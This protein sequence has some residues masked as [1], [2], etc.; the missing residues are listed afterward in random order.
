MPAWAPRIASS[1]T[2][3][4]VKTVIGAIEQRGS[5][6]MANR[7]AA[8]VGAMFG[9]WIK[10]G[11][12]AINPATKLDRTPET[13]PKRIL[14]DPEIRELWLA[15]N[16]QPGQVAAYFRICLL[17]GQ[18]RSEVAGMVWSEVDMEEAQ[19]RLPAARTKA[20]RGHAVPLV[21]EAWAIV[22]ALRN[23]AVPGRVFTDLGSLSGVIKR[24]QAAGVNPR[25]HDLRRTA[26]SLMARA[27]VTEFDIGCVLNHAKPGMASKHYIK[28]DY[29]NEKARALRRLD[30]AVKAI[31]EGRDHRGDKVVALHAS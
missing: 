1:L 18:R 5:T 23:T 14:S 9:W 7:T 25:P 11:L 30:G 24:L 26:S 8:L 27:G 15:L 19:W 13:P 31:V 20:N 10:E 22:Q 17:T 21:G 12:L 29:Q 16:R 6:V 28:H 4:D 2:R 3:A